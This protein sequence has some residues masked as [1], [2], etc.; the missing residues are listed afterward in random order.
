MSR[1]MLRARAGRIAPF[2]VVSLI[3]VGAAAGQG[4]GENPIHRPMIITEPGSYVVQRGFN[5]PGAGTA[6][7]IRTDSVTLDLNGHTLG[8]SGDKQGVGI[9]VENATGV[10]IR[11][12]VLAGFGTG[13][14]V[15]GSTNVEIEKLQIAGNDLGGTPPNIEVGILILD[16]RGVVVRDNLVTNTFL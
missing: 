13:V 6:V 16:S 7:V 3:V 8:G 4:A 5:L 2:L 10:R 11:G 1:S 9:L 14:Q 12:G 15:M